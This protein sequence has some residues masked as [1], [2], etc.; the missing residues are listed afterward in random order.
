MT[1]YPLLSGGRA[2]GDGSGS[3]WVVAPLFHAR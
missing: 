3:V 2:R 1:I